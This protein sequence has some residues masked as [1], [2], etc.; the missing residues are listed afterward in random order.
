MKKNILKKNVNLPFWFVVS[1]YSFLIFSWWKEQN[2]FE[3]EKRIANAAKQREKK[4]R[5]RN[6][7]LA[8]S[9][10]AYETVLADRDLLDL[11]D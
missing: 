4:E 3:K 11:V 8:D 9:L 6:R 10:L 7:E 5:I 2:E 1:S